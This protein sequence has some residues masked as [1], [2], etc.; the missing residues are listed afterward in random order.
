[1]SLA[2]NGMDESERPMANGVYFYLLNIGDKTVTKRMV[3]IDFKNW[4][5]T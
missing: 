3:L 4:R 5:V 1:M 2:W